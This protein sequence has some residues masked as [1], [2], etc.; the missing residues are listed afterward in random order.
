MC[1]TPARQGLSGLLSSCSGTLHQTGMY[2]KGPITCKGFSHVKGAVRLRQRIGYPGYHETYGLSYCDPNWASEKTRKSP[3]FT[4]A[5]HAFRHQSR[6]ESWRRL[7]GPLWTERATFPS[8][9][10]SLE[11]RCLVGLEVS[12]H[13]SSSALQHNASSACEGISSVLDHLLIKKFEVLQRRVKSCQSPFGCE[14]HVQY[15]A[16]LNQKNLVQGNV[17][18]SQ[19]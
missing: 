17:C 14:S 5:D 10:C 18:L 13:V 8:P 2:M 4:N 7:L 16:C 9:L 1:G 3:S 19:C 12:L 11:E 15:G 6:R